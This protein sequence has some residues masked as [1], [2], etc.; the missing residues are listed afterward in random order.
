MRDAARELS[1]ALGTVGIV[2]CFVRGAALSAPVYALGD[3]DLADVDVYTGPESRVAAIRTLEELGFHPLPDAE[4]G[5]PPALRSGLALVRAAGWRDPD[6]SDVHVDLHWS[7]DP[8]DRLLPRADRPMPARVWRALRDVDGL[9]APAP[10][11]HAALI[12][13]HLVHH[14][15]LHVRGLV[16]LARLRATVWDAD[17]AE[18]E[19]L[20]EELGVLNAARVLHELLVDELGLAPPRWS[21]D[22]RRRVADRS[23]AATPAAGHMDSDRAIRRPSAT[24]RHHASTDPD[25]RACLGRRRTRAPPALRRRLSAPRAPG[26]ALAQS[27]LD[28][29]RVV[30]PSAPRGP[31]R[32]RAVTVARRRRE[33]QIHVDE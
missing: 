22:T 4:Q 27:T 23:V 24:R 28:A 30:A 21:C 20:S 15:F 6:F 25:P 1:A 7:L 10:A 9:P 14:D 17:G 32:A 13:Q 12:V 8:V 31:S 11:H 33:P 2:H 18:Y 26:V 16:D 29:A 19:R 3:R 5:G